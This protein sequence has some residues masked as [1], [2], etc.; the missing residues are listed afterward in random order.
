MRARFTVILLDQMHSTKQRVEQK[1]EKN[2][3]NINR[4]II[5]AG[6]LKPQQIR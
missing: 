5:E 1:I 2:L 4:S 6:W 3:D